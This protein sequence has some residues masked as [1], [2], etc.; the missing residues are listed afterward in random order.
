MTTESAE[1]RIDLG[2]RAERF[3]R[4]AVAGIAE[5][6]LQNPKEDDKR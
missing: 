1:A 2:G 6:F 3:A 5:R 4:G